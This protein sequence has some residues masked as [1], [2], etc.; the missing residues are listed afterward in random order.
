MPKTTTTKGR[1][2]R[3]TAK[4]R[5][6][7]R[8]ANPRSRPRAAEP[9]QANGESVSFVTQPRFTRRDKLIADLIRYAETMHLRLLDDLCIQASIWA[10]CPDAPKGW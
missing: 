5:P 7:A 8:T 3:G 10:I 9:L 2:R 1:S 6:R 4:S